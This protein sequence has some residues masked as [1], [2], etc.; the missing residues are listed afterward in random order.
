MKSADRKVIADIIRINR[1]I[2]KLANAI[3][4]EQERIISDME[5]PAKKAVEALMALDNRRIDLCNLNVLY[6]VIE[7]ELG[8]EFSVFLACIGSGCGCGEGALFDK[9]HAAIE[10]V[11]YDVERVRKEFSYLFD[12]LKPVFRDGVRR[13]RCATAATLSLAL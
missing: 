2:G 11:G 7:R 1:Y 6:G 10:L 12:R 5:L 3:E 9:A 13:D 8:P 4:K